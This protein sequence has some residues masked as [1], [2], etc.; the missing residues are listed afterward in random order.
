MHDKNPE[1]GIQ[2]SDK[3]EWKGIPNI[4]ERHTKNE[5]T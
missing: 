3:K 1:E 5:L 2:V 4:K